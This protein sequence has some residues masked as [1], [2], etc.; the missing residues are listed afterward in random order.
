VLGTAKLEK[1]RERARSISQRQQAEAASGTGSPRTPN[2]SRQVSA[3]TLGGDSF[4]PAIT[5]TPPSQHAGER[6]YSPRMRSG[7][8][9]DTRM[10]HST[11]QSSFKSPVQYDVTSSHRPTSPPPRASVSTLPSLQDLNNSDF[12]GIPSTLDGNRGSLSLASIIEATATRASNDWHMSSNSSSSSLKQSAD[13]SVTSPGLAGIGVKAQ[14]IPEEDTAEWE[15]LYGRGSP[16]LPYDSPPAMP[17]S[18]SH[19]VLSAQQRE[20]EPQAD[21]KS[22]ELNGHLQSPQTPQ[23]AWSDPGDR[24]V[25]G[26]ASHVS[27]ALLD[28]VE[29][30]ARAATLALKGTDVAGPRVVV[31]ARSKSLSRRKG[32][33]LAKIVSQPQLI[34]TSQRLDHAQTLP[35]PDATL[36][37]RAGTP[38]YPQ[39]PAVPPL[40]VHPLGTPG[41]LA[42]ADYSRGSIRTEPSVQ[43]GRRPSS[44][45]GHG[46]QLDQAES[47][48]GSVRSSRTPPRHASSAAG[49]PQSERSTGKGLSRFLSR[50]RNRKPSDSGP[51]SAT[52]DPFPSSMPQTGSSPSHSPVSSPGRGAPQ[53]ESFGSRNEA[54]SSP[55][56]PLPMHKP[57]RSTDLAGLFA[58][59]PSSPTLPSAPETAPA[60]QI[61]V[62]PDATG[63]AEPASSETAE[64]EAAQESTPVPKLGSPAPIQDAWQS[65]SP[66]PAEAAPPAQAEVS[67]NA[68]A[69]PPKVKSAR[70]TII[71]RT[72]IIPTSESVF[73][74]R[75]KV[76][77]WRLGQRVRYS[78]SLHSPRCR[79]P[80]AASRGDLLEARRHLHR[81]RPAGSSTRTATR[82]TRRSRRPSL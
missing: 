43:H 28:D 36:L 69:R 5:S 32:K 49:T 72:I 12:Q 78:P 46:G 31:P 52:V 60:P 4:A 26:Q 59:M 15:G 38:A 41:S 58:P 24:P 8:R 9:E 42:V 17:R 2:L 70:D 53:S 65:S 44:S 63:D 71:R 34:Q 40:P 82:S 50:V 35:R 21:S 1:A 47:T 57:S 79:A 20:T 48:P 45:F 77:V 25:W 10:A 80:R 7:S 23:T 18:Q 16:A 29:S 66:A 54:S 67:D 39:S 27:A 3:A 30:H 51:Y 61:S 6:T 73:D 22:P 75:R 14:P 76:R 19:D 74:E 11:S 33:N 37:R 13:A 56:Q 62:Q 68:Q 81:S 55:L 64:A